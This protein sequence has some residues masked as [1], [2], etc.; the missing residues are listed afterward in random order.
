MEKYL[1]AFLL[2]AGVAFAEP[3]QEPPAEED[4][5][6]SPFPM[7][8]RIACYSDPDKLL[9]LLKEYGEESAIVSQEATESGVISIWINRDNG[10][11][12]IVTQDAI[13]GNTC[14]ALAGKHTAVKKDFFAPRGI[15]L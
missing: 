1:I 7:F 5:A 11:L 2:F 13:T 10:S 4:V 9:N 12:S 8:M 15:Q 14:L 6:P 3:T